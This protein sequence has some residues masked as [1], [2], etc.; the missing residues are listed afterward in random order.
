MD[1]HV[2]DHEPNIALFTP[3][4]NYLIFYEKVAAFAKTHLKPNGTIYMEMNEF[5]VAEIQEVFKLAGYHHI[6]VRKDLQGK[7]RMIRIS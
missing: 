5:K 7:E 6:D 1:H 2:L 4:D 3:D